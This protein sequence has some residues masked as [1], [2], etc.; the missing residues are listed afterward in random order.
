[1]ATL[2]NPIAPNTAG[3]A[4]DI[5]LV[6]Q[7]D[8]FGALNRANIQALSPA[9]SKALYTPDSVVWYEL[10]ALLSTQFEMQLCGIERKGVYDWVMASYRPGMSKLWQTVRRQKG[11]SI[12]NPYIIGRQL[13]PY[14]EE[15]WILSSGFAPGS[16]TP[17][18]TG[19]LDAV[20]GTI[21][22]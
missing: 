6:N 19:P 9:G 14:N 16:Y 2:T 4:C 18:T 12:I 3:A 8:T 1:M 21:N 15:Y 22:T 5:S 20:T 13:S 7:Y 17:N 10:D 11:P